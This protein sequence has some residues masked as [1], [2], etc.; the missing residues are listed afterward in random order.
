[1]L[2]ITLGV[3]RQSS[4]TNPAK[5]MNV[6]CDFGVPVRSTPSVGVPAKKSSNDVE[7]EPVAGGRHLKAA[8]FTPPP[9]KS[10]RPRPLTK[11]CA[12]PSIWLNSP[13]NL[14]AYF[15]FPTEIH[16]TN[17]HYSFALHSP[18]P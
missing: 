17:P 7:H 12:S 13:P 14:H 5:F 3:T 11:T 6:N 8:L 10:N 2:T 16:P 4:W 18:S 9:L 15:P 1:M